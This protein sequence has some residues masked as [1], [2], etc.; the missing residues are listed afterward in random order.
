MA[1]IGLGDAGGVQDL[2][3]AVGI[4]TTAGEGRE[5]AILQL[6][7]GFSLLYLEGPAA[8][9]EELRTGRAYAEVRGIAEVGDFIGA[10]MMPTLVDLGAFDEALALAERLVPT[11]EA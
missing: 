4:A 2:R 9:V 3:E 8:S 10:V 11:L 5:V 1:R 6:N 7:L